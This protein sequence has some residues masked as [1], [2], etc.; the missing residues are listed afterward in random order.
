MEKRLSKMNSTKFLAMNHKVYIIAEMSAN[1][2]GDRELAK[3]IIFAAKKSGADAVKIQTYTADTITINCKRGEFLI[4]NPDSLWHGENL[5][6]LYHKAHTPWEWQKELKAYADKIGIDFFS[7]P[8][9]SSAVDFLDEM[10]IP[11]FKI[12]SFEAVDIP[13]IKYAAS[14]GKPM[15]ISTGIS[16]LEEIEEAVS[17]CL[18]VG[19]QD[20][21][22][23]KCTSAYPAKIEEMNLLTIQDMCKYFSPKGVKIGL[24]DHSMSLIPPIAAVAL[25]ACVIEKHFTLD[26][27]LGGADSEFSLNPEEF[28]AMVNAV[29]KTELALGHVS[30]QVNETNRIFARSLYVVKD[31]KQGEIIT[32]ENVRSIRPS[33][34]L[35]P[36][37]YEEIMGKEVI[38]DLSFGTPLKNEY[39]K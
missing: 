28:A 35:H 36:R 32:P 1:H 12:A 6:S 9:V 8:F 19:N 22:L 26:R 33:K 24:S 4:D 23:L 25:G 14:K 3:K 20:I 21:V 13:L 18:S 17:A 27:S 16:S 30:Y 5:Y 37:Y 31:I 29:R 15:I 7:T 10:N 11:M 38:C 39:I 2:C 34:G